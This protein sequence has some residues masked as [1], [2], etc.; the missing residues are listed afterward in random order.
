LIKEKGSEISGFFASLIK[1]LDFF[2]I[3]SIIYPIAIFSYRLVY[4]SKKFIVREISMKKGLLICLSALCFFSLNQYGGNAQE[5]TSLYVDSSLGT[6]EDFKSQEFFPLQISD[7]ETLHFPT[8]ESRDFYIQSNEQEYNRSHGLMSK[9]TELS[10]STFRN[11]FIGY[12][13]MTPDWAFASQYVITAGRS[14][15]FSA[16]YSLGG[17]TANLTVSTTRSVATTIPANAS[18]RSRLG[19]TADVVVARVRIDYYIGAIQTGI[20][21][22]DTVLRTIST[23]NITHGV[24]YS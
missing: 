11:K 3:Y 9:S 15:S 16:S 22:S 14:M 4:L 8:E 2:I 5:I 7:T 24:Y 18:R 12:N 6:S 10:R 17:T 23:S 13:S 1:L 20:I 19:A 21:R